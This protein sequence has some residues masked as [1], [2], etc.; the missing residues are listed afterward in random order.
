MISLDLHKVNILDWVKELN[1]GWNVQTLTH[2]ANNRIYI[3]LDDLIIGFYE[4]SN[5]PNLNE[6][7]KS[8]ILRYIDEFKRVKAETK[9]K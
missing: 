2:N 8:T 5:S 4:D 6:V 7:A 3:S 9:G 1:M